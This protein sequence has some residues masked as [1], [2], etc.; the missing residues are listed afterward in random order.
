MGRP[1]TK[2]I[3]EQKAKE[4]I[5]LDKL[6]RAVERYSELKMIIDEHKDNKVIANAI[7]IGKCKNIQDLMSSSDVDVKLDAIKQ[8]EY[9]LVQAGIDFKKDED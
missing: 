2:N 6:R 5:E 4:R 7:N 3:R 9:L 1:V 8:M